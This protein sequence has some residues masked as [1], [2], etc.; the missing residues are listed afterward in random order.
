MTDAE[1]ERT[2]EPFSKVW[3]VAALIFPNNKKKQTQMQDAGGR[4]QT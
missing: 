2:S 4:S 1:Q 3:R